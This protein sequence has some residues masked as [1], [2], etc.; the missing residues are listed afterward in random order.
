MT[1]NARLLSPSIATSSSFKFSFQWAFFAFAL[2]L[3]L[4]SRAAFAQFDTGSVLGLIQDSSGAVIPGFT[5]TAV[6]KATG[7]ATTGV[8]S[9]SGEYEIPNLHTGTYKVTAEHSG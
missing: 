1:S 6:N 7:V 5:V 4:P 9:A 2:F 8:S 3:L